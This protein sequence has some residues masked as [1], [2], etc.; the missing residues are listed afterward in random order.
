MLIATG[1]MGGNEDEGASWREGAEQMVGE[2]EGAAD[3]PTHP[4]QLKSVRLRASIGRDG[5]L[6][7]VGSFCLALRRAHE[8]D[9]KNSSSPARHLSPLRYAKSRPSSSAMSTPLPV[10]IRLLV[11]NPNSSKVVTEALASTLENSGLPSGLA[12]TYFT[13]TKGPEGIKDA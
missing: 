8:L 13:P 4:C 7:L 2:G 6:G 3:Q 10:E 1:D 11:L 9:P 12:V 5:D